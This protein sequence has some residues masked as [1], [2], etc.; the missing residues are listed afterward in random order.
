MATAQAIR[1]RGALIVR[2]HLRNL[3]EDPSRLRLIADD[4]PEHHGARHIQLDGFGVCYI[5][6]GREGNLISFE[7]HQ[8][9]KSRVYR[10]YSVFWQAESDLNFIQELEERVKDILAGRV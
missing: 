8:K 10:K 7:V 1:E 6:A 9:E 2:W 5:G 3:V 4:R